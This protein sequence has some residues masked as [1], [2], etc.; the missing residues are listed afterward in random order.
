MLRASATPL[1]MNLSEAEYEE[2]ALSNGD[3]ESTDA[4]DWDITFASWENDTNYT[5]KTDTWAENNTTYF[6]NLYNGNDDDN[7]FSA[8][9]TVFGLEAGNYYASIA[10]EG[11]ELTLTVSG[12]VPALYW[13]TSIT[14]QKAL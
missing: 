13:G 6:L 14:L 9:Y 3:L 12:N 10:F 11:G 2:I 5:V 8:S 1:A 4:T 7:A